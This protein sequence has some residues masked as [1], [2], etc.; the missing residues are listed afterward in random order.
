MVRGRAEGHK[1]TILTESG[2]LVADALFSLG[3]CSLDG[4]SKFLE[5]GSLVIVQ[6]CEVLVSRQLPADLPVVPKWIHD[7]PETPS[8]GVT[9][10]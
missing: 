5:R 3:R 10:W 7:P 2:Q 8:V 1:H 9:D 4:P 6:G